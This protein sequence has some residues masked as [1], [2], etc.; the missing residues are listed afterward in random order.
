MYHTDYMIG[1]SSPLRLRCF[2]QNLGSKWPGAREGRLE[3]GVR[4]FDGVPVEFWAQ[5]GAEGMLKAL[6]PL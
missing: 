2:N 6:K 5:R 1:T 4:G 3:D